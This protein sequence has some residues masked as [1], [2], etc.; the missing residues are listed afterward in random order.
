M[1]QATALGA[2]GDTPATPN[3]TVNAWQAALIAIG[4]YVANSPWFFGV[5][6]FT[7]YRPLVAGFLVGCI[8]GDPAQGTLTRHWNSC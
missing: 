1:G 6:Y 7:L 3:I 4:Y 2:S 5:W 8:L